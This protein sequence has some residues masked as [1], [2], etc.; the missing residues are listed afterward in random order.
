MRA[1]IAA[2][3]L[4][5]AVV[6]LSL[7]APTDGVDPLSLQLAGRHG[8]VVRLLGA[9]D[10]STDP[11]RVAALIDT[12]IGALHD[13][14]RRFVP[15]F[16]AVLVL[17]L[18]ALLW[19]RHAAHRPD[20]LP[21]RR[22]TVW[23]SWTIAGGLAI[24]ATVVAAVLDLVEN[25]LLRTG[26][27]EIADQ[28]EVGGVAA[29][30]G[31]TTGS[32][33]PWASFAAGT[34]LAL[35]GVAIVVLVG[36]GA[37][38]VRTGF[39]RPA[40]D[41]VY[42]PKDDHEV[43]WAPE[44]GRIGVSCSGGGVRSASFC[45]GALQVLDHHRVLERARYVTA[46]SG[47]SYMAASWAIANRERAD[48]EGPRVFAPLSPEERWVR[49]HSSHLIGSSLV[50]LAG[51]LRLVA[52][53]LFGWLLLW[54]L[55]FSVARP[56]GWLISSDAV[57]PELRAR[58]PVLETEAQPELVSV[59][60]EL[61]ENNATADPPF[62]VYAVTPTYSCA[63]MRVWPSTD[64]GDQTLAPARLA[65]TGPGVVRVERGEATVV[66][67]PTV[68]VA[69]WTDAPETTDEDACPV[70]TPDEDQFAP[71]SVDAEG[72]AVVVGD[73]PSL[74]LDNRAFRSA[75][76]TGELSDVTAAVE[77]AIVED[78]SPTVTHRSGMTGRAPIDL[79]LGHWLTGLVL[80]GAGFAA[81][82]VRVL[83]R[84]F[85]RAVRRT[86]EQAAA[87]LAL[88]GT[89]WLLVF[90]V[91]PW[92]VQE[93]PHLINRVLR[94]GRGGGASPD[95]ATGLE[96]VL[97]ALGIT[98]LL[99]TAI[100]TFSKL[101]VEQ[102]R[103]HLG[104]VS[105]I[106]VG[107]LVPLLGVVVFLDQ[108]EFA[109][110]NGPTGRMLGVGIGL[111]LADLPAWVVADVARWVWVIA[112]LA[113]LSTVDAHAWSLFPFYKRRLSE[114]YAI[115]RV[116]PTQAVDVRY[117]DGPIL[118]REIGPEPDASD[119]E[120]PS[121]DAALRARAHDSLAAPSPGA[122]SAESVTPGQLVMCCAANVADRSVAPPGRRSVSF[123]VS[124]EVVGSPELGWIDT[125]RY[126][127]RLPDRRLSD[128]TLPS[129]MA[130][131]GAAV[132]PGMGKMSRG[133]IDSLL[134]L[135]NVRL[136]VWLP[137]P[138]EVE[139]LPE[140][141]RWTTRPWWW[142]YLR[143]VAGAFPKSGRFLYVSDGGHWE[144][145][146]LVELFRR[147]CTEIYCISAAGD[148][149]DSFSTIGEALALVR[150]EMAIDVDVDL[151]PMRRPSDPPTGLARSL[152]RR[153]RTP[154]PEPVPDAPWSTAPF[155]VGTFRYPDG[156]VGR[157]VIIEANLTEQIPWDV[158][159]W[160]EA[161]PVFP[162][163]PTTDQLFSHRQ[164][165]SYRAL[166]RYQMEAAYQRMQERPTAT[167]DAGGP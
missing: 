18:G 50:F 95:G 100:R 1:G 58:T 124:A 38:W 19:A 127:E 46:V 86:L 115:R 140:G 108:L 85:D 11:T 164:F 16:V 69:E 65:T 93:V 155:V 151:S 71:T 121:A 134:A 90:V 145:L 113:V 12:T 83:W 162:D 89:T 99:A 105:R 118:I 122:P 94:L 61:L 68:R 139:A 153:P 135:L 111:T 60:V 157:L 55:S 163:D 101:A 166:G 147:G 102:G 10:P 87:T 45:L 31:P 92:A 132:S 165:E 123:T 112:A 17:G 14:D 4:A 107:V 144:N 43:A 44:P 3:Y 40:K 9:D 26:L 74:R 35:L 75:P 149:P 143:E 21:P 161:T 160:A 154:S 116:T 42:E 82:L 81:Y 104:L 67:Q 130:I 52:G 7:L 142:W 30:V 78:S 117:E 15:A 148:G 63:V 77:Q 159:A 133:P 57:H 62:S 47:G 137:N 70:A 2:L 23:H 91:L 138:A 66:H 110:A 141:R 88:V 106:V 76:R 128:V 152:R 8:E 156:P 32:Q 125:R 146:G 73:Q 53:I 48:D 98:G 24:G 114:A 72:P 54:L 37:V 131:S 103:A 129:L 79:V 20:Q 119:G 120:D 6:V 109:T 150:E 59:Q 158:Q 27:R 80:L 36:M 136:G 49:L 33:F 22:T 51:A 97:A 96:G 5:A 167:G 13:D 41:A 29:L 56:V 25:A 126:F 28:L 64:Q 34:K 39:H 84:P